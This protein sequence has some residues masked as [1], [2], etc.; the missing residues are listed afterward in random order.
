MSCGQ[1]TSKTSLKVSTGERR[2]MR[3][4]HVQITVINC[5]TSYH[6]SL[7]CEPATVFRGGIPYTILDLKLG[8]KPEWKRDVNGDLTDELQKQ[9]AELHQCAKDNLTQSYLK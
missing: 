8:L 2:S 7:G 5:N 4:E 6:E 3:H 1:A 9:I